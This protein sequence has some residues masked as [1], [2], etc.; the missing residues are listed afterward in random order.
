MKRCQKLNQ[1]Q[2]KKLKDI[3]KDKESSNKEIRR[4]QAILLIDKGTDYQTITTLTGYHRRQIFDLRK[5]YLNQGIKAI[6]DKCKKQFKE[7]LTKKQRTEIIEI[8]TTKAPKEYDYDS[9]HWTTGILGDFIKRRYN[10][11][12]K[13][14]TSYY[15]I[16]KQAKFTYHKPGR[17][18][19]QK[20]EKE[21]KKWRKK[22][23]PRIKRA[24]EDSNIVVLTGDEMLLS[25]QTTV[26]KIWLPQGQY[27]KIEISNKKENR[28]IYGFLN[29]KTGQEHAFKTNWQNMYITADILKELRKSYPFQELL[30]LWDGAGWHRGFEVQEFIKEDKN[31]QIIYFPKYTPELNPQEYV[32][33]NGRNKVSHNKFIQDIDKSADEFVEYLNNTK[34]NYSLLGYSANL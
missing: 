3:I 8:L 13:S 23:K 15:L 10:I 32:W 11:E 20:D 17:Q 26:Q 5:N 18:Y 14:K 7:L 27:P 9:E 28:S 21:V 16:F 4:S 2:I 24:F 1:K 25:T 33:K 30:I 12:Y 19:H 31:I 34:F 6:K 22:T 29:I